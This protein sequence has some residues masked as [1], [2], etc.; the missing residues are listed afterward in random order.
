MLCV[1]II[2]DYKLFIYK[3]FVDGYFIGLDVE[4]GECLVKVF[5]VKFEIVLIMWLMLM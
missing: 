2:G 5:G 4:M 3:N 1:G